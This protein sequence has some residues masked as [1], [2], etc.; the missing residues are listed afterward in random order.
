MTM[1]GRNARTQLMAMKPI[2]AL[3]DR[4]H[5]LRSTSVVDRLHFLGRLR[6][7][8]MDSDDVSPVAII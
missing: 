4:N 1:T 8:E 2:M 6:R 3:T 5:R 7:R